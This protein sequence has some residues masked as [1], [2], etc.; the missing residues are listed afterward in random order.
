MLLS[1][2]FILKEQSIMIKAV[3]PKDYYNHS[4]LCDGWGLILLYNN[5]FVPRQ[6]RDENIFLREGWEN[7][8]RDE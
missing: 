4:C 2:S 1:N 8:I 6:W 5:D 7:K 3:K